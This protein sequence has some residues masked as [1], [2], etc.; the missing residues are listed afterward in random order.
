MNLQSI[1]RMVSLTLAIALAAIKP[2]HSYKPPV[3]LPAKLNSQPLSF[4]IAQLTE[5]NSPS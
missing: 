2:V 4:T 3:I 1:V 5:A